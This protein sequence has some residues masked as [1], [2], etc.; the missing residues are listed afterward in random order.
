MACLTYEGSIQEVA[1]AVHI[2]AEEGVK[3][4]SSDIR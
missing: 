2:H 4:V 3:S 1:Q